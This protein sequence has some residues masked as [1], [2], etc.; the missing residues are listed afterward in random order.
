MGLFLHDVGPPSGCLSST[1]GVPSPHLPP[2]QFCITAAG[3]GGQQDLCLLPFQGASK[4][5]GLFVGQGFVQGS[6]TTLHSLSRSAPS[7]WGDHGS[8]P[9]DLAQTPI[10][11]QDSILWKDCQGQMQLPA[12]A[13]YSSSGHGK[14]WASCPCKRP[15]LGAKITSTN[16]NRGVVRR[17]SSTLHISPSQ[18][19]ADHEHATLST[20]TIQ[21]PS[22]FQQSWRGT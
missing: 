7:T 4:T 19:Q 12:K 14:A 5:M 22:A 16:S 18:W 2:Q 17:S 15:G 20:A 13:A 10:C 1:E 6:L 3:T 11:W 21:E 8:V 9:G